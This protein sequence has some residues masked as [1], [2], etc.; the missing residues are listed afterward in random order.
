MARGTTCF[1]HTHE[2]LVPIERHH[3]RPLSRGGTNLPGNLRD[4]CANAHSDVHYFLDLI[5]RIARRAATDRPDI[6]AERAAAL[7]PGAT[8]V[9]FGPKVR[10]VAKA[11][12]LTYGDEFLQGVWDRHAALWWSSGQPVDGPDAIATS[13][14]PFSVALAR[15]EVP[16][17]LSISGV[18]LAARRLEQGGPA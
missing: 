10:Q 5:E 6:T 17:W 11:G 2:Y 3:V 9:H 13:V 1:A 8:A 15:V 16:Y 4:G 12:W 7:V 18:Y 14:P